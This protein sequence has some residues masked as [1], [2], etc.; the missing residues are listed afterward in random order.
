MSAQILKR[1]ASPVPLSCILHIIAILFLAMLGGSYIGTESP[2]IETV[3][4]LAP[5]IAEEQQVT[6][7]A[8]PEQVIDNSFTAQIAQEVAE[9]IVQK[10]AMADSTGNQALLSSDMAAVNGDGAVANGNGSSTAAYG[11]SST[12]G[13]TDGENYSSTSN[14]GSQSAGSSGSAATESIGSIASRFAI[15]VESN[16]EY[17]YM[18]MKRN[19]QGVVTVYATISAGGSLLDS[20][21]AGSS[22][23]SSLDKAALA[24][25]RSSCPFE[26][27]AGDTITITVPIHFYLQ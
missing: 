18:A 3:V 15:R 9:N 12:S 16:K 19:Q 4:E 13:S 23:V 1:A 21:I 24:A 7:E 27:G 14:A 25:V 8:R 2:E 17:P 26:H 6:P 5:D 20:G 10:A 11:G 22:G